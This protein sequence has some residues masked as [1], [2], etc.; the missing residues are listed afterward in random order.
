[1]VRA[2]LYS[3]VLS[4]HCMLSVC[5]SLKFN[6]HKKRKDNCPLSCVVLRLIFSVLLCVLCPVLPVTSLTAFDHL[7]VFFPLLSDYLN[8]ATCFFV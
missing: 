1:M 5:I 8:V 2:R 6:S 7:G 3:D 4:H